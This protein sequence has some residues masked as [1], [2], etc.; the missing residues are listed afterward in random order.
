MGGALTDLAV[1]RV[2]AVDRPAT[3]RRFLIVKAEG[4]DP[5][6]AAAEGKALLAAAVKAVGAIRKAETV[7][8]LDEAG[9]AAINELVTALGDEGGEALAKAVA[10]TPPVT[11]P[12]TPDPATVPAV[13]VPAVA[14]FD[15]KAF[16][17]EFAT[18]IAEPLAKSIVAGIR[19]AAE[20]EGDPEA[21]GMGD[22]LPAIAP[23]ASAQPAAGPASTPVAKANGAGLFENVI[24]GRQ[25]H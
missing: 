18:A 3:R 13:A 14:P 9:I 23:P 5:A 10:V 7:A 1:E 8:T 12:A 11:P 20:D 22:P 4:D 16:A 24:F 6:A 17:T 15:T 19:K 25:S 2:D 21:I